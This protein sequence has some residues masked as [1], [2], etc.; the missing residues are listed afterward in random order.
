[1]WDHHLAHSSDPL[2]SGPPVHIY[3][4]LSMTSECGTFFLLMQEE[5]DLPSRSQ[6]TLLCEADFESAHLIPTPTAPS[7]TG[8][9]GLLGR[10]RMYGLFPLD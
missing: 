6:H 4:L 5:T 7:R 9:M 8:E 10:E 3:R 2:L 1:M